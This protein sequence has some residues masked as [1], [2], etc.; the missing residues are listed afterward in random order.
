MN[1]EERKMSNEELQGL[2]HMRHR[3]KVHVPKKGRD[4]YNRQSFKQ[5]ISE[6]ANDYFEQNF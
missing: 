5:K 6:E 4:S 2:L 3:D 1:K